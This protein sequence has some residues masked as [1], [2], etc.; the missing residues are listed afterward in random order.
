[1]ERSHACAVLESLS[2]KILG[3][4]LDFIDAY[5]NRDYL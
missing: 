4:P 2:P 5:G 1:M 3:A